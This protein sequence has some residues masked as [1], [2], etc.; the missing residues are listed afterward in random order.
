[1]K[2][3][4]FDMD[5][6]LV[7]EEASA[8][9][10]FRATCQFAGKRI[11]IDPEALS[12]N[13]RES[14]RGL[15]HKSPARSF[16]LEVG[17][18]SWEGLWADF[19]GVDEDLRIL[20]DWASGYRRNS[21]QEALRR[22][23]H[24]SE[25][26]FAEELACRFVCERRALNVVYDDVVPVLE[27]LNQHHTLG[28]LTN[29]APDLQRRKLAGSGLAGYFDAVVISGEIGFG[30]PDSRIFDLILNRLESTADS[31]AMIGNSLKS[32]I[33]P[34]IEVGMM[35]IWVNR[36]HKTGDEFIIPDSTIT[37]LTG[38][39]RIFEQDAPP[40]ADKRHR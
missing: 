6:T 36:E 34:A 38:L 14:C 22:C 35:G 39:T 2:T 40:D 16:C 21:W 37:D 11:G 20:A 4:I 1:M 10:A 30:K 33:A 17:I 19:E 13:I 3:L 5:D 18:S 27:H 32:D 15:W 25:E 12:Q 8:E 28:L 29:G 23:G 24:Q 9:A 26:T 31:A 7:V